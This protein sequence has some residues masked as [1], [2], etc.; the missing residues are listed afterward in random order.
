M[1]LY[2]PVSLNESAYCNT[3]KRSALYIFEMLH[4]MQYC[5]TMQCTCIYHLHSQRQAE[6]ARLFSSHH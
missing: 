5:I 3:I 1:Y 6:A 2:L 4:V